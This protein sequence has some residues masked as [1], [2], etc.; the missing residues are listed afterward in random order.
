MALQKVSFMIVS[1]DGL[2]MQVAF[3]SYLGVTVSVR[4]LIEQAWETE[5]DGRKLV[6]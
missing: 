6:R 3:V 1:R 2:I 5:R 4:H